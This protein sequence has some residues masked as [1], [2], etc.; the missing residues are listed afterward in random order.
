MGPMPPALH[1]ARAVGRQEVLLRLLR[2]QAVGLDQEAA[3]HRASAP[4]ASPA[5]H[6][7]DPSSKQA[8]YD[9]RDGCLQLLEGRH[10]VVRSGAMP[11]LQLLPLCSQGLGEAN[12]GPEP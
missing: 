7:D 12:V 10:A 1:S 5:V 3:E 8:L 2:R 6:V 4:V 11:E 9:G